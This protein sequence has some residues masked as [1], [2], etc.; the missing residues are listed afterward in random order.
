MSGFE[1]H[2]ADVLRN[3]EV[4]PPAGLDAQVFA[5]LDGAGASAARSALRRRLGGAGIGALLLAGL[6]WSISTM[7]PD[8]PVVPVEAEAAQ[9]KVQAPAAADEEVMVSAVPLEEVVADEPSVVETPPVVAAEADDFASEEPMAAP[10]TAEPVNL[11]PL[12]QL[13]TPDLSSGADA[14]PEKSLQEVVQE[15]N[16]VWRMNARVKVKED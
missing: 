6:G 10:S 12:E 1:K 14:A 3:H 16:G 2:M 7:T 11:A 5:A 9:T 13:S 15:R 4:A 8:G